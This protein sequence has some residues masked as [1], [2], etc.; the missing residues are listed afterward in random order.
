MTGFGG[1]ARKGDGVT[2]KALLP[3]ANQSGVEFGRL[4][5]PTS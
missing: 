2:P 3:G 4:C 1:V 5:A